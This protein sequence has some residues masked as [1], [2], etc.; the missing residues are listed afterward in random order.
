MAAGTKQRILSVDVLRGLTVALMILVNNGHGESFRQLGHSAWN[1]LT[2]CDLV[3]PFFLFIMGLSVNLSRKASWPQILRR[4]ALILLICWGI[5]Y[6][7][8]A[9]QGDFWPWAHFRLTGV[10]ARIALCYLF[11]ALVRRYVPQQVVPWLAG[12]LLA[13]YA[14]LLLLGNGY[15]PDPSNVLSRVDR[16]LLGEGHLSAKHPVDPEGLLST[17]PAFGHTLL[18]LLCGRML[19]S[20]RPLG[21]RL[22]RM[23]FYGLLLAAAG[24][25]LSIWLPFNKRV[26]SPSFAL[27]TCGCCALLLALIAWVVD[28][29]ERKGWTPFFTA[30][31]RNALAV[32]VLSELLTVLARQT[33]FSGMLYGWITPWCP[34]PRLASLLY[35]LVFVLVNYLVAYLLYRKRIFI[36]L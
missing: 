19:L 35:A 2:L 26:W 25:L 12:G 27:F 32:Y 6:F 31:G 15:S 13:G 20:D 34:A 5:R 18:G 21:E 29:R 14:V 3:F 28:V 16:F 9:L 33:G 4:T 11:A 24:L 17:V 10:L 30:F 23:A 8:C 1:G 22:R 36:K 7:E